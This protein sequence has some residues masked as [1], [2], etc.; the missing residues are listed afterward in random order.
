[1]HGGMGDPETARLREE[2]RE[3]K[4]IAD[5]YREQR[6][7]LQADWDAWDY[8]RH[9]HNADDDLSQCGTVQSEASFDPTIRPPANSTAVRKEE[10]RAVAAHSGGYPTRALSPLGPS[11]GSG[12]YPTRDGA[13]PDLRM[14]PSGPTSSWFGRKEKGKPQCS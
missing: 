10:A 5:A 14:K 3:Y 7:K 12:G 13:S 1:M 8:G 4:Q 9:G 6:G 11:L 2:V